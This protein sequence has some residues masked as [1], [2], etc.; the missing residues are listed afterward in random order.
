M[1]DV[2]TIYLAHRN[3]FLPLLSPVRQ[4][5]SGKKRFDDSYT[6]NVEADSDT[7]QDEQ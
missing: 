6:Q 4:R 5:H 2:V 1:T 7:S 3:I